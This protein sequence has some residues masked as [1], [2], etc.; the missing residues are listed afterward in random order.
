MRKV[1]IITF[2]VSLVLGWSSL[3]YAGPFQTIFRNALQAQTAS[4]NDIV[5]LMESIGGF[6]IITGAIL[7]GIV[8]IWSGIMYMKAGSDQTRVGS[9]K[10]IFK[11]GLIGALI[12]FAAGVIVN[13]ISALAL[14]P[15][16]F[17]N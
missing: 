14:D 1:I 10:A 3:T 17:F 16:D 13:T 9:A 6:L 7:A 8:I 12:L 4:A 5:D 11:N 2:L 15:F